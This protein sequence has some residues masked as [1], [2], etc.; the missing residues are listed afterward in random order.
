[1]KIS[2][3]NKIFLDI[4]SYDKIV[5]S[6]LL[7]SPALIEANGSPVGTPD[8]SDTLAPRELA[9]VQAVDAAL[10]AHP[11]FQVAYHAYQDVQLER[12][13]SMRGVD[14]HQQGRY[15]LRYHLPLALRSSGDM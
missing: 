5:Y 1:M 6:H 11:E 14:E 2:Q 7:K 9:T 10:Q 4:P 12:V 8:A 3:E 15:C 13:E